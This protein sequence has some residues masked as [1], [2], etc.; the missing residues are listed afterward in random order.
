MSGVLCSFIGGSYG[1][2]PEIGDPFEGGFFAGYLSTTF[3]SVATHYLIVSPKSS[4]ESAE[5][6]KTSNTSTSGAGSGV[7]GPANTAA[8]IAEGAANY[9]AADFCD[10]LT[11]GGYSDWYLPALHE[12]SI[13]YFNLKPGTGTN[14]TSSGVNPYSVPRRYTNYTNSFP[15]QTSATDFQSGNTEALATTNGYTWTST[16]HDSDE[17]KI[18]SMGNG[19][20]TR[21]E[22]ITTYD[23]RAIRRVAI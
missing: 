18:Q 15:G 10:G 14:N 11:I 17:G 4:G 22:K 2:P 9:P 8:M 23:V 21:N 6:W 1:G 16:E 3:D 12:L 13:L 20:Q 19:Q 5:Q 7:D